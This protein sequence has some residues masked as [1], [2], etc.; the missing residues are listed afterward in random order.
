MKNYIAILALSALMATPAFAQEHEH[1]QGHDMPHMEGHAHGE[2]M[3]GHASAEHADHQAMM[4]VRQ[5][6]PAKVCMVN[7]TAFD[8]DQIAVEVEGATY[9]GCCPMCKERLEKDAS[10][11]KAIDPVSGNEVD[12]AK[13]VIGADAEGKVHYFESEENLHAHMAH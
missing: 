2:H 10:I 11:R 1:H 13:A 5:V 12:K 6:E 4:T 3:A 8:T 9:Y 7:D